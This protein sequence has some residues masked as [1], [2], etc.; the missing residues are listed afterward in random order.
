MKKEYQHCNH[1][2]YRLPQFISR[3]GTKTT[4]RGVPVRSS[5]LSKLDAATL[6]GQAAHLRQLAAVLSDGYMVHT[7]SE[8]AAA[9]EN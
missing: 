1:A 8:L 6:R 9:Y 4:V 2:R 7:V 5:S 3:G